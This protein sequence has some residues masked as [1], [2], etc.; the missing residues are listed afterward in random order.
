MRPKIKLVFI[1]GSEKRKIGTAKC[2]QKLIIRWIF[3]DSIRNSKVKRC[4][5]HY[6]YDINSGSKSNVPEF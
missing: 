4:C 3:E 2:F 6:V 5:R 1:I